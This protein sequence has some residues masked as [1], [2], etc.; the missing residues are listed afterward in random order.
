MSLKQLETEEGENAAIMIEHKTIKDPS[1][2]S[3]VNTVNTIVISQ[4][5]FDQPLLRFVRSATAWLL[6]FPLSLVSH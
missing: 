5:T 4:R 1:V 2:S 6:A 3:H